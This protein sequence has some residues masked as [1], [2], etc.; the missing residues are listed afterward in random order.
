MSQPGLSPDALKTLARYDTPTV[1]NVIE[2]FDMRPANTGYMD[3]R[4]RSCF[5]EMP[6]IVGYA[7]TAT[8]R[9]SAPAATKPIT[10]DQQIAHFGELPGPP[11]VVFQDLDYPTVAATFGDVMCTVYKTFG[12]VGLITSGA[13]RDLDQVRSLGFAVF[14]SGN[15]PSHGYWQMPSI[16]H[17][18]QVGGVTI[19]PGDLMHAD[20]NG[21]TTIPH[22]IASEAADLCAP[23]AEAEGIVLGYLKRGDATVPGLA[24]AREQCQSQI[25][26]LREQVSRKRPR[27]TH[28]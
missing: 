13:A 10:I 23:Y 17:P 28:V 4:I 6:P 15:N 7:A 8:V 20:C 27:T 5:P 22:D 9:T 25:G 16:N 24:E 11:V 19:Q 26:K 18:V 1:C 3:Q 12:A 2:L 14:A 21:V